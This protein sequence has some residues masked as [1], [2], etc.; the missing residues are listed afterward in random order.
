[1]LDRSHRQTLP[2]FFF[3]FL[4]AFPKM[5]IT[6]YYFTLA[7]IHVTQSDPTSRKLSC[8]AN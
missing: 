4:D 8:R 6:P 1:M 5:K 3:F 2:F 7:T